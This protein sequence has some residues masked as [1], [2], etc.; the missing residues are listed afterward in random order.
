MTKD[1]IVIAGLQKLHNYKRNDLNQFLKLS[2][3]AR[4]TVIDE[5]HIAVARTYRDLVTGL[6]TKRRDNRLLGLTATP[7]RTWS[8]IAADRELSELFRGHKVTITVEGYPNPIAFLTAEEYLACPSFRL[9]NSQ[10]GLKMSAAEKKELAEQLDI[11]D[12]V[13]ARLGDDPLRNLVLIKEIE[14]LIERHKRMTTFCSFRIVCK[15]NS[16]CA[17]IS[18]TSFRVR[19]WR[20]LR[21]RSEAWRLTPSS[22]RTITRS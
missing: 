22:L 15:D 13:L 20:G 17:A 5:A 6:S 4:L 8:D 9:L 1:G 11:P 14:D 21:V 7:G 3:C 2:D 10:P 16:R 18:R 19:D 12:T